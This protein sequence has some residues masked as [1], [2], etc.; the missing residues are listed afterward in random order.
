MARIRTIK[1]DFWTDEKIVELSPL[2][3]LLFIGLWNFA[4]DD[5]RMPYSPTRIKLQILPA[6]AAEISE[7]LGEIRGKSLIDVYTV[8]SQEYL[9]ICQ[10]TRHQKI[11]KR[12]PSKHPNPPIYSEFPRLSP[13]SPDGREGNGRE[14]EGKKDIPPPDLSQGFREFWNA[15]PKSV[16]KASK[17][18]CYKVWVKK[19]LDP[20]AEQIIAHVQAMKNT[21]GWRTGFDP[22]PLVYL[23]QSR[24]DGAE[25]PAVSDKPSHH[26]SW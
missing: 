7:L 12:T 3:R 24:W 25:L 19:S 14:E 11:D 6:D 2:A 15:W 5:G 8:D 20:F 17:S 1:P 22:A 4:D 18:E 9:H 10:F 23:N 26:A 13:T 16:R 21:E